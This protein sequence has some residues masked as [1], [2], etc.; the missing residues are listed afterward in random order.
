P[1]CFSALLGTED[2]GRW[3]ITPVDGRPV[4]RRYR[5]G[6]LVLE[7]ELEGKGGRVRLLDFMPP[8]DG[9]SDIVRIVEGIEGSVGML[10]E[11]VIRFD[12]GSIVPW[13]RRVDR[14]ITA[15][16]GP[17]ALILDAEVDCHG[18][19]L[20]TIAEFSVAK[21]ERKRFTLSWFH[22]AHDAPSLASADE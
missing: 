12:Y 10:M 7:T 8:K 18:E 21:G 13:V 22:S 17:D 4:R 16:G 1:S 19:D 14:G 6:S 5:D 3:L 11:L 15:I 20:R 2:H 9:R